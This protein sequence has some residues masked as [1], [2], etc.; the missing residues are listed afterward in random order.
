MNFHLAKRIR[1][2][3]DKIPEA[4]SGSNGHTQTFHVAKIL[5]HGFGL[6]ESEALPFMQEYSQ[7]CSPPWTTRDLKHKLADAR[8]AGA[9]TIKR[10]K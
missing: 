7:R 10:L 8:K 6:S 2:Y 3:L 1:A 4:V 5:I 9:G